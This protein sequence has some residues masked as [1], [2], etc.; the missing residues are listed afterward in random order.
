M[1]AVVSGINFLANRYNKSYDAT[2][3]KQFTLS[4]QT[5][6]IAKGL[7]KNVTIS[8]WDQPSKFESAR[9]LLNRYRNLSPKINV[10]YQDTDKKRTQA[11][12]AGVKTLGTIFVQVG[13][14]RQEAKALT[15]EDITG[16]M[17]RALKGGERTTCFVTGSGEH[18]LT[19]TDRTGYSA[20]KDL[21]DKNNYKTDSINLIE[22]PEVPKDCTVLVVGGPRRN[23]VQPEV[24][25]IKDYVENGGRALI[26]LDPP[27]KFAR[28]ETD[29]NQALINVLTSWGVTPDRDLVLDTSGIGQLYQ[30][31]PEVPLISTYADHAITRDM[32]DEATG[33]PI[34]RSLE[35]KN[36]DKTTVAKAIRNHG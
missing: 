11:I 17:I 25:A 33:F 6:K 7:Q 21:L 9:D 3:N 10:Q 29:D 1:I 20:L 19:D 14:N 36:G 15:E 5:V 16:A 27:L 24:D 18:S 22:K 8:Y 32:K 28:Q 26:M 23:Y 4:D 2:A 30:M 34:A 12:A 35:I 13:N 31:G